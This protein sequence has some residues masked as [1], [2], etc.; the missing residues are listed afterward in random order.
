MLWAWKGH[1]WLFCLNQHSILNMM[2]SFLEYNCTPHV[3]LLLGGIVVT[4]KD[5]KILPLSRS[6]SR[7]PLPLQ[8]L[9]LRQKMQRCKE[10]SGCY[11][12]SSTIKN[13]P[14]YFAFPVLFYSV[15]VGGWVWVLIMNERYNN[16]MWSKGI[17]GGSWSSRWAAPPIFLF[18][19]LA[20]VHSVAKDELRQ[21]G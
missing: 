21:V 17:L 20:R 11:A 13:S 15:R 14:E 2:T 10:I 19:S 9:R 6:P 18:C 5:I 7:C 1:H 4:T 8:V 16:G 3:F 12:M